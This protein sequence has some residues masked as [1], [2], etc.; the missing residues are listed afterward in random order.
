MSGVPVSILATCEVVILCLGGFALFRRWGNSISEACAYA[1]ITPLMLLSALFQLTFISGMPLLTAGIEI[2]LILLAG[3]II[4]QLRA[5][6]GEGLSASRSFIAANPVS[7]CC[8][9]LLG[10]YLLLAGFVLPPEPGHWPGLATVLYLQKS[11]SVLTLLSSSPPQA[12]IGPLPPL[13]VTILSHLFLRFHTDLGIGLFGFMAYLSIGFTTYAL[14]RRYAWPPSAFTV[15]LVVVAMPRVVLLATTPG[16]EL[17]PA[18]AALFCLLAVYRAIEHPNRRDLFLMVCALL[19]TVSGSAMDAAFPAVM[20][21]L[22]ALLLFRRH[23]FITWWN[24]LVSRIWMLPIALAV[25]LLFSQ[26]WLAALNIA[27][28][29][30][31]FATAGFS[32]MPFNAD[33]IQGA[34]ANLVR[35]GF[36]SAHFTRPFDMICNWTLGFTVSGAL[37]RFYEFLLAPLLGN[38]GATAPFAI[39]WLPDERI[40][41]FGPFGFLLV[42]PAVGYAAIRAPRRLKAIAVGL[43][44][45]FFLVVLVAAWC[46]ENVR[47]FTLFFI[48][49]GF[50]L[51]LFLPPWYVSPAGRRRLQ[52]IA[53]VLVL[54]ASVFNLQ[55]PA[56]TL[57]AWLTGAHTDIPP[58]STAVSGQGCHPSAML[59]ESAWLASDWGR[60]RLEPSTR[61][62]G[63]HRVAEMIRQIPEDASPGLVARNP[64]LAYPFLMTYPR[65]VFLNA[66]I[67][68][69]PDGW[70]AAA[71]KNPYI[72]FVD[73]QLP[74]VAD[75]P[76]GEVLWRADPSRVPCGGMLLRFTD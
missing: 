74:F 23:G 27:H 20:I 75:K 57:P 34:L 17:L 1:L 26:L 11:G 64:A 73:H 12:A 19:F 69:Q 45:Y 52:E 54:Y 60:D 47:F 66:A 15:A 35:Y 30:R 61:L 32:A 68:D 25:L 38:L 48:C 39:H 21:P 33:G 18:A 55:K 40:A 56:L 6:L 76:T 36:S 29:D 22:S 2:L 50:T 65:A 8:A 53:I 9:L 28:Q 3:A 51:A 4:F 63:D 58:C 24:L 59:L 70:P 62:F 16:L 49:G 10:L 13:N 37:E 71:E 72:I 41:W 31:W 43:A 5:T 46:P 42:L 7:C 44:G 67:I 14:A